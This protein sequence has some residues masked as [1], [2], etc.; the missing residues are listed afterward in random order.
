QRPQLK[1]HPYLRGLHL[2]FRATGLARVEGTGAKTR[3]VVDAATRER[4]DALNPTEQY[5]TLL[6]AWLRVSKAEMVGEHGSHFDNEA[7]S[8]CLQ[9][10]RFLPPE[11]LTFDVKHP[12]RAHVPG[13]YGGN[14]H[15]GLMD[16][17]GLWKIVHAPVAPAPWIPAGLEHTPFG[18]AV[19]TIFQKS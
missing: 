15:V 8:D 17:F 16:L 14:H 3:L 11:G 2:L 9:A 5:F 7:F 1:S 6:E 18:D 19:F 4:W 13:L 12:E 10:W